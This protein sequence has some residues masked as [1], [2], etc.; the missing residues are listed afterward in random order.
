[1]AFNGTLAERI[2]HRLARHKN[3]EERKMFGG[4]GSLLHGNMLV[5]VRKDSLLVRL[6]PEQSNGQ[7]WPEPCLTSPCPFLL[8]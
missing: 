2:Q 7:S 8:S 6:D 5:G 1:M 4:V 3:V